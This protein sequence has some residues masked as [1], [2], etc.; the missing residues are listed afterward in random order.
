MPCAQVM[1]QVIFILRSRTL[2]LTALP[3]SLLLSGCVQQPTFSAVSA[4]PPIPSATLQGAAHGGLQPIKGATVQLYSV[5]TTGN[6]SAATP[7]ITS[8][9]VTTSDGTSIGGNASNNNNKLPAGNFTITNDYTCPSATALVYITV[10]GGNAGGGT[11]SAISL[12]AAL[13]QCQ[14]LASTPFI[15]IN[16]LSTVAAVYALAPYITSYTSI[17]STYADSV[18]LSTAFNLA[19]QYQN[20]ATGATPG[21]NVP[22]N[23]TVPTAQ[24]STIANI[25]SNCVNS[26]GSTINGTPCGSLFQA[27]KPSGG[28]APTETIGAT[29]DL[30]LNATS[31]S[32]STLF[33]LSTPSAP[34][35]PADTNAPAD[36]TVALSTVTSSPLLATGDS[37]TVTQP[38]YP[39]VCQ[40]LTAQFTTSQRPVGSTPSSDDTSRIATALTACK[41]TGQS[42]VLAVN[43]SNN[44]F[45]YGGTT[46]TPSPLAIN[47]EGLV[48][49]S[50]VTLYGNDA[51]VNA[52]ELVLMSGTNAS[53]MGP[54]TIDGR[55]DIIS[56]SNTPRLVQSTSV[57][58]G[59]VYNV[60][61]TQALHPNLYVQGGSGFTIWN[62]T[63]LTPANRANADGIDIDSISNV[64]VHDSSVEAGDDGIAVKDNNAST[65]NITIENNRIYGTHGLSIGSILAN[66]VSNVLFQNNYV[67]GNGNY[68]SG[69]NS[70]DAN[71]INIKTTACGLT[72]QQV[73]YQNTCITTAKHLLVMITNYATCS[74]GGTASLSD[75]V[76]NG[77]TSTSSVSGAYSSFYGV[78]SSDPIVAYLANIHLDTTTQLAANQ[79]GTFYLNNSNDVPSGTGIT[80]TGTF[81]IN[82]SVPSCAF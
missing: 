40:T 43:G 9:T 14:T 80:S 64:T 41:G 34:Y 67:Y 75:I 4:G 3:L 66:T 33:G 20:F 1:L 74:L 79:Y 45:F 16:E 61:L 24:L 35:Q 31:V 72:V 65:S 38:T 76:V 58:G 12:M 17:G 69:V 63:I 53:L 62:V 54:G 73:T 8:I 18:G 70:T 22:S 44:A 21:T 49:N 47:G 81:T 56:T 23:K 10:T 50:G 32:P 78:S 25:L 77:V 26:S 11:N 48:L 42:V 15:D 13:G 82:G 30:A 28:S 71:A 27:V 2:L 5:G 37:R 19:A 51:Y 36:W 68:F 39:T 57:T 52:A 46:G 7:L 6:G 59:S 60:T 55:G 29:L